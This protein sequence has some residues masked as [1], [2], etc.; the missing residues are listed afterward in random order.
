MHCTGASVHLHVP[1]HAHLQSQ[2]LKHTH[3]HLHTHSFTRS[4]SSKKAKHTQNNPELDKF[5]DPNGIG[6][7]ELHYQMMQWDAFAQ[8]WDEVVDDLREADLI[9][10]KEVGVLQKCVQHVLHDPGGV[11]VV[12]CA[13]PRKTALICANAR[14]HA[15]THTHTHTQTHTHTFA[16]AGW[17]P[18]VR[19]A[20]AGQP[21][22]WSPAHPAAHLLL[23][24]PDPQGACV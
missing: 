22:L 2:A 10:N 16:N 8:A 21:Q 13:K 18:Q 11:H 20:G 24:R 23:C 15:H 7:D 5:N 3:T 6:I 4:Q 19:E 12:M 9:S 17:P 14:A 1:C